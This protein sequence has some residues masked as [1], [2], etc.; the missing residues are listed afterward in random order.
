M[1]RPPFADGAPAVR[2]GDGA[3][4]VVLEQAERG[5]PRRFLQRVLDAEAARLRPRGEHRA[6]AHALQVGGRRAHRPVRAVLVGDRRD[7]AEAAVAD[8][9]RAQH[10]AG[11]VHGAAAAE[12][13]ALGEPPRVGAG[14]LEPPQDV[15][16]GLERPPL[17]LLGD[18]ALVDAADERAA[19][20]GEVRA[21][22]GGGQH[23]EVLHR[24]P[25]RRVVPREP[26]AD[27]EAAG[28]VDD[29]V[30]GPLP[31]RQPVAAPRHVHR[32]GDVVEAHLV[33]HAHI[34][35]ERDDGHLAL[36]PGAQQ[37]GQGLEGLGRVAPAVQ[38]DDGS[39]GHVAPPPPVPL[40]AA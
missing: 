24:R 20:V 26:V 6:D 28:A 19:L 17:G 2:Q 32:L 37:P 29:G 14:E 16:A 8:E 38:D 7:A 39:F 3:V 33:L 1:S 22:V 4:V 35:G 27:D 31:P 13:V 21:E 34:V 30:D 15:G 11:P 23:D 25:G 18:E 40:A 5:R 9:H 36:Q 12:A 10:V